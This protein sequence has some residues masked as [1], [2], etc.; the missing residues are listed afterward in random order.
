MAGAE[1]L[2]GATRVNIRLHNGTSASPTRHTER[3]ATSGLRERPS[4]PVAV[5]S[6]APAAWLHQCQPQD[7]RSRFL[8]YEGQ[9]DGDSV[10]FS[11]LI[12]LVFP[13]HISL[14]LFL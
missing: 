12:T 14:S 2:R 10:A 4:D 5:T 8:D 6:P 13:F 3:T 11:E 1:P 7:S 9:V